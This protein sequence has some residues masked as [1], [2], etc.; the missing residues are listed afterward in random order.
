MHPE[1][2]PSPDGA[3]DYEAPQVEQVETEDAPAVIAAGHDTVH[4]EEPSDLALKRAIGPLDEGSDH[5][6]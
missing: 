2:E 5:L 4:D 1:P 6:L 3:Q